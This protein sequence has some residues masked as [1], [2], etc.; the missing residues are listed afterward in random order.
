ML[1]IR[2][3]LQEIFRDIFNDPAIVL[4]DEMTAADFDDWD[5][6]EHINIIIATEM[7]LDTRFTTSE[8]ARLKQTDQNIGTFIKLLEQKIKVD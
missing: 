6:L 4:T 7:A 8:I 1:D 3:M 5:S 2:T